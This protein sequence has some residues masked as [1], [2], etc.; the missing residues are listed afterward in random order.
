MFRIGQIEDIVASMVS[1]VSVV[2][3]R[4]Y[5]DDDRVNVVPNNLGV[6]RSEISMPKMASMIASSWVFMTCDHE[7]ASRIACTDQKI[8]KPV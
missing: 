8:F 1:Q 4:I 7:F 2:V 5:F 3:V 6:A